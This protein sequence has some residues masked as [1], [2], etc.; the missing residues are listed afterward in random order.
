MTENER[1]APPDSCQ[2]A[3]TDKPSGRRKAGRAYRRD[4]KRHKYQRRYRIVMKGGYDPRV[5]YL[6]YGFVDG[7][8]QPISK[9]ILYPNNSNLQRWMKRETSVRMRRCDSLPRKGNYYRRLFDYWWTM[10]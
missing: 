7:V 4:M 2:S 8:W 10:Y 5:G 9:V 3:S 6:R 1:N